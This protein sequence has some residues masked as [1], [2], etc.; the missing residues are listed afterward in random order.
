MKYARTSSGPCCR[1]G[2]GREIS[3]RALRREP[4][5]PAHQACVHRRRNGRRLAGDLGSHPLRAG[6]RCPDLT[7]HTVLMATVSALVK[8]SFATRARR[9]RRAHRMRIRPELAAHGLERLLAADCHVDVV[10]SAGIMIMNHRLTHSV[11]S[12]PLRGGLPTVTSWS[13]R[14]HGVHHRHDGPP[15]DDAIQPADP[16]LTRVQQMAQTRQP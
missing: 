15:S 10:A 5:G 3:L 6:L 16:P 12:N 1:K 2:A 4:S 11:I 9:R 7:L 14:P 13:A 8:M